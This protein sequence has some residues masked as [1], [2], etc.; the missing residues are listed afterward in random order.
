MTRYY[1]DYTRAEQEHCKRVQEELKKFTTE[2]LQNEV[3]VILDCDI[4]DDPILALKEAGEDFLATSVKKS[5]IDTKLMLL[6]LLA[7]DLNIEIEYQDF[8]FLLEELQ[9]KLKRERDSALCSLENEDLHE[10]NF[11]HDWLNRK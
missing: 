10:L 8:Y 1:C 4:V 2:E 9:E 7:D 11:H 5:R 3:V 6:R